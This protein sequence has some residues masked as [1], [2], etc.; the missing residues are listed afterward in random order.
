MTPEDRLAE[1]GIELPRALP[2]NANYVPFRMLGDALYLSGHGPRRPDNTY[3]QGLLS[4]PDQIPNAY[5]DARLA[6]LNMLATMKLALGQLNRVQSVVKLL[7]MVRSA[8]D[9]RQHSK[10]IDG[11]SDLFV[12]VFGERGRHARSAVGLASLPHGMT[13]EIEAIFHVR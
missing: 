4:A 6:G 5:E 8:P 7:G 3:R 2:P 1:L 9:F 10:V 13:V 11:C 12:S